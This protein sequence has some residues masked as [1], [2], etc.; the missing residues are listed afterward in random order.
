M[1]SP[2]ASL[3]YTSSYDDN[4]ILAYE[5]KE[6]RWM[7]ILEIVTI[8]YKVEGCSIRGLAREHGMNRKTVRKILSEGGGVFPPA[9]FFKELI[10]SVLENGFEDELE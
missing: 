8:R 10:G 2:R 5:D 4:A 1:G 6:I 7:D 9:E 3:P